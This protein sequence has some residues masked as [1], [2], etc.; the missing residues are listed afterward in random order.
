[1]SVARARS[2]LL[3]V[4]VVERGRGCCGGNIQQQHDWKW[5]REQE[6]RAGRAGAVRRRQ[7]QPQPEQSG[8]GNN[9]MEKWPRWREPRA[10]APG[11]RFGDSGGRRGPDPYSDTNVTKFETE[12]GWRPAPPLPRPAGRF[13]KDVQQQKKKDEEIKEKRRE[14]KKSES[15]RVLSLKLSL[16]VSMTFEIGLGFS[17]C[18]FSTKWKRRTS[19]DGLAAARVCRYLFLLYLVFFSLHIRHHGRL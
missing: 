10:V 15:S 19:F 16:E 9:I 14:N 1:M 7:E 3:V 6:R 12:T 2:F 4:V 18:S 11:V 5:R 17:L 8:R 13:Q